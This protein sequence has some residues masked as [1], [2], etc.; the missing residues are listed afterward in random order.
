[1]LDNMAFEIL[2]D[3]SEL[4]DYV[5]WGIRKSSR[6]KKYAIRI[7]DP[8]PLGLILYRRGIWKP[9]PVKRKKPLF[10]W[11]DEVAEWFKDNPRSKPKLGRVDGFGQ[12]EACDE[13]DEGSKVSLCLLAA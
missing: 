10:A 8:S 11:T 13:R 5:E 9:D 6:W 1:M 7:V 3:G 4:R 2:D 12:D